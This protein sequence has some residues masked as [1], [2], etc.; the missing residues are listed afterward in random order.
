MFEFINLLPTIGEFIATLLG[1]FLLALVPAL[2][3]AWA[4][5]LEETSLIL[6][7][8]IVWDEAPRELG[9]SR[10]PLLQANLN[11][12]E[13]NR[14]LHVEVR[15]LARDN[16]ELQQEVRLLQEALFRQRNQE[17][18]DLRVEEVRLPEAHL[19]DMGA[20]ARA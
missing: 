15:A 2:L 10:I 9:S 16:D 5:A 13:E 3:V 18:I 14:F 17:V 12:K 11:L 1:W 20:C 6:D 19:L 4:I 7:D 8:F